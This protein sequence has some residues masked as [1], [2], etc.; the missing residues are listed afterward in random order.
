[1]F[2]QMVDFMIGADIHSWERKSLIN[3][4]FFKM[5]H[6]CRNLYVKIKKSRDEMREIHMRLNTKTDFNSKS[7][8]AEVK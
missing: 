7:H 5:Q 3:E 4:R 6:L 1:M 2:Y 8:S